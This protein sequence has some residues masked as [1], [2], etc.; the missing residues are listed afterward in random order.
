MSHDPRPGPTPGRLGEV[1]HAHSTFL[2]KRGVPMVNVWW[3][4]EC[5]SLARHWRVY[6]GGCQVVLKAGVWPKSP[7]GT[8]LKDQLQDNPS[9]TIPRRSSPWPSNTQP[10]DIL[11]LEGHFCGVWRGLGEKNLELTQPRSSLTKH[12]T[13]PMPW[14]AGFI[15]NTVGLWICKRKR[16]NFTDTT[17]LYRSARSRLTSQSW[18]LNT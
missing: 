11:E 14:M 2:Q 5:Y 1:P 15:S 17:R 8:P 4:Q 6:Q 3:P 13:G 9:G 16:P 7:F 12:G 18:W 10:Q